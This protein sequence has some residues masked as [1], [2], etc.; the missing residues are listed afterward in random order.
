LTVPLRVLDEEAE[1]SLGKVDDSLDYAEVSEIDEQ[2]DWED[3]C[4]TSME[5]PEKFSSCGP[6][7]ACDPITAEEEFVTPPRSTPWK[8]VSKHTPL[9]DLF[10]SPTVEVQIA[11]KL[12]NAVPIRSQGYYGKCNWDVIDMSG[13]EAESEEECVEIITTE[14]S[15][16]GSAL[17]TDETAKARSKTHEA[18]WQALSS[19]PISAWPRR[20]AREPRCR[21]QIEEES[22]DGPEVIEITEEE[23]PMVIGNV[24]K[25]IEV[26]EKGVQTDVIQTDLIALAKSVSH[27]CLAK[28]EASPASVSV[29]HL[30]PARA[31]ASLASEDDEVISCTMSDVDESDVVDERDIELTDGERAARLK[32]KA[33]PDEDGF[34]DCNPEDVELSPVEE[35]ERRFR[36]MRGIT[37]DSGAGDPVMPRRMV[38]PALIEPSSGSKRGLHYVS[39]TDHRIPNVGQVMMNFKTLHEGHEGNIMFQV[40]DVNK[41]LMSLSER[42][43]NRCRIVFD[44]DD[45]TGEDL[46]HIF[47][48]KTRRKMKLTRIGKVWILDCSVPLEFISKSKSSF[49]RQGP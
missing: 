35:K 2:E 49:R 11:K 36:L 13:S 26:Y 18:K 32:Q 23:A 29:S 12:Q 38:N 17:H 3:M 31:E 5:Q 16:V 24:A 4:G 1:F 41:A 20:R 8:A 33:I 45:E 30:C 25:L 43:D 27:L 46:T 48:K 7:C 39:A 28:A 14:G 10:G 15:V 34:F 42:V 6:E 44:Q 47:D 19:K 40:A 37:A 22:D 21:V 9:A